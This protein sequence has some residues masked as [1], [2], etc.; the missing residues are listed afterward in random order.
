MRRV[1][2]RGQTKDIHFYAPGL[3]RYE[4]S[5]YVQVNP[6][7]FVPVSLTGSKCALQCDHCRGKLLESMVSLGQGGLFQL[8]R[9]MKEK[10]AHGVLVTGGADAR[11][12]VPLLDVVEDLARVKNELAMQVVVHTGLV[13]QALAGALSRAGIDGAMID[14]LGTEETIRDVYHLAARVEDYDHA[15]AALTAYG[16]PTIPHIVLGLHYGRF[17][18]ED[19]ALAMV[20]RYPVAALVLV[21]L[22]PWDGTPMAG[23]RPPEPPEVGAF[24]HRARRALSQTPILLGCS[25]PGGPYKWAVDRLAVDAGLDGIAYPADGI[26]EY[27]GERGLRPRFHEECCSLVYKELWKGQS[28]E[29]LAAAPG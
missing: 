21:I 3:K 19:A 20:A 7:G 2:S 18:G 29:H 25:R 27:A 24:F 1:E 8:C 6:R 22:T 26:V 16:V 17:L 13:R 5:E 28:R 15:L 10:G 11:G 23:V 14:I 12:N 9:A 4:T